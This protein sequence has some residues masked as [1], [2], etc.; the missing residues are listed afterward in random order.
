[1]YRYRKK[2]VVIEA[3]QYFKDN[4]DEVFKFIEKKSRKH[5]SR[6]AY[7]CPKTGDFFIRTLE[8]DHKAS[9][10]DYIIIGVEG[11]FYP[12][13]PDILKKTYEKVK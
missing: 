13:K 8:G 7:I 1:M 9:E 6:Y 3:M 12:C 5:N 4:I 2:P 10:G 11:E